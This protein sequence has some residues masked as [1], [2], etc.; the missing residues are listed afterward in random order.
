MVADYPLPRIMYTDMTRLPGVE[1]MN[2]CSRRPQM[3]LRRRTSTWP[4][5]SDSGFQS[6]AVLRVV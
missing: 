5:V 2:I 3:V 1:Q 4:V 6:L